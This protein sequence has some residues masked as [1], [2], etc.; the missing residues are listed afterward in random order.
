MKVRNTLVDFHNLLM[1]TVERLNDEELSGDELDEELRRAKGI[2][3]VGKIICNNASNLIQ[4]QKI[5]VDA[6]EY[7]RT[8]GIL[9]GYE[10]SN[11]EN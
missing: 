10:E 7:H 8:P 5:S 2:T 11:H 6:G 9:I 1:E 3:D 4:A